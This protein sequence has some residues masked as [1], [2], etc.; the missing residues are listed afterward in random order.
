[1][2]DIL[3][4]ETNDSAVKATVVVSPIKNQKD[5]RSPIIINNKSNSTVMCSIDDDIK[6]HKPS[7][8]DESKRTIKK[9]KREPSDIENNINQS[10][11]LG[12]LQ[13][14][15]TSTKQEEKSPFRTKSPNP[16]ISATTKENDG[17]SSLQKLF[18][19][20][21]NAATSENDQES[22]T[23]LDDLTLPSK[24]T[25]LD[26]S[27]NMSLSP[28]K[29]LI[30]KV[31]QEDSCTIEEK[32]DANRVITKKTTTTTTTVTSTH[33][34][35]EELPQEKSPALLDS[36]LS[37]KT[38]LA[39]TE[40]NPNNF[41]KEETKQINENAESIDDFLNSTGSKN[42]NSTNSSAIIELS[43]QMKNKIPNNQDDPISIDDDDSNDC[44]I[45][46]W[47][48]PIS[49]PKNKSLSVKDEPKSPFRS[50]FNRSVS[51]N[52]YT[53]SP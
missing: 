1:M 48:E 30:T 13:K 4:L 49:C 17:T 28:K 15:K 32:S 52:S 34:L 18:S 6:D 10:N 5:E 14:Y 44:E 11:I 21:G 2:A 35:G 43:P 25:K 19:K 36:F 12:I 47:N 23:D 26:S 20:K 3:S 45:V 33:E 8:L 16:K 7:I 40:I 39:K 9:R 50:K 53:E 51:K 41:L 29:K 46:S 22:E 37:N 24:K 38:I 27:Q 31:V 42:Q